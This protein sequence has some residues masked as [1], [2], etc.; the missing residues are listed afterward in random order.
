M[1]VI[2]LSCH[3]VA[4]LQQI[5]TSESSAAI[6]KTLWMSAMT[7]C[8]ARF[9]LFFAHHS[10]RN[11]QT[12]SGGLK[13]QSTNP[14]KLFVYFVV[15]EHFKEKARLGRISTRQLS[16]PICSFKAFIPSCGIH[17]CNLLINSKFV[18][19]VCVIYIIYI[20]IL[21]THR[22]LSMNASTQTPASVHF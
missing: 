21:V 17:I 5:L 7:R 18:P 4:V 19:H 2:I 11:E 13:N 3:V 10:E 9:K 15:H 22:P 14:Q 6:L 12:L 16:F 8:Q 20:Y 1:F